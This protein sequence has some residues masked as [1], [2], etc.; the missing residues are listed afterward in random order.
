MVAFS[1]DGKELAVSGFSTTVIIWDVATGKTLQKLDDPKAS[2]NN[3]VT[4]S[5]AG[6][7]LAAANDDKTIKIWDT[8]SGKLTT[9]LKGTNIGLS[10]LL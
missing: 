2:T 5:P 6:K 3:A 10:H 8:A 7:M 9:Q 1:A 4:F